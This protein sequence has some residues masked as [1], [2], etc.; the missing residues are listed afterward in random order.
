MFS[1]RKSNV[2]VDSDPKDSDRSKTSKRSQQYKSV[3]NSSTHGLFS[4]EDED[5]D[6]EGT[7]YGSQIEN[8]GVFLKR[9]ILF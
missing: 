6:D 2:S 4:I 5:D 8:C 7:N 3:L 9:E 1:S